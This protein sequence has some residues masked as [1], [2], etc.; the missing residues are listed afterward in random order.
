ML[1]IILIIALAI[2]VLAGIVTLVQRFSTFFIVLGIL[3][4]LAFCVYLYFK[5][6]KSKDT[7]LQSATEK[8]ATNNATPVESPVKEQAPTHSLE[9]EATVRAPV[10][11]AKPETKTQASAPSVVLKAEPKE[12]KIVV[13]EYEVTGVV[14]YLK[15]LLSMMEPNYLWDYKK[16][17]L[18]DTCNYDKPIYKMTVASKHLALSHEPDNPHDPNAIMVLL[19]DKLVGYIA[20]KDSKHILNIIDNHLFVTPMCVVRGG[21][22]KMVVEE[23][24]WE[25]DKSKYSMEH[26][27]DEYG[28]TIYIREKVEQ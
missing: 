7:H 19:D 13:N 10:P 12:P 11:A 18:I 23:Y 17:D 5:L 21:K 27:E 9:P 25:K 22:Y 15:N 16:Q 1:K 24:D 26:G 6:R 8:T 2:F 20:A 4:V 28:I 14:F 3:C